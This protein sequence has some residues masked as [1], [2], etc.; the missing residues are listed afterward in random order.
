VLILFFTCSKLNPTVANRFYR[1]DL[2]GAPAGCTVG[3]AAAGSGC[4]V[5]L[6]RG[7]VFVFK[8]P[9]KPDPLG[10]P[11]D[12]QDGFNPHRGFAGTR[13]FAHT[14]LFAGTRFLDRGS[15]FVYITQIK[16]DH[17][18]DHSTSCL[19]FKSRICFVFKT[20]TKP[21]PRGPLDRQGRSIPGMSS[22]YVHVCRIEWQ[23][24]E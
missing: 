14:R 13:I 24:V 7:S 11:L 18:E 17:D 23:P 16:P 12:F 9:T 5:F 19:F 2:H 10:V 3:A 20:P 6:N 4:L 21:D 1:Q 22:V 15:V 8:A